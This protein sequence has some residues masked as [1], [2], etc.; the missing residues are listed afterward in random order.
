MK[1]RI[2]KE[3][4]KSWFNPEWDNYNEVFESE[5]Y[6]SESWGPEYIGI[7]EIKLW[8]DKWHKNLYL[9]EWNIIKINHI[10]NISF[11][12]WYF[13][14]SDN[15]KV[16][17]FNGVSIIEWGINDKILSL[18]EFASSL[19]KYNPTKVQK[20]NI[21]SDYPYGCE[22]IEITKLQKDP[23]LKIIY[24]FN[25]KNI[26]N[27]DLVDEMFNDISKECN[28]SKVWALF[29]SNIP[30][31][32]ICLQVASSSTIAREIISDIKCMIPFDENKDI[33]SWKGTFYDKEIFKVKYGLDARCQ[34][35]NNMYEQFNDFCIV[36]INA[37]KYLKNIDTGNFDPINYAE[38]KFAN[39]TKLL[40]WR[41]N[42]FKKESEILKEI[43]RKQKVY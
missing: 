37:E 4:F 39:D 9:I 33:K 5:I 26:L 18:K 31:K 40:Y 20:I 12:E 8:K 41:L 14:C 25:K 38:V 27:K 10:N 17:E 7:D 19:P 2:I 29:G 43:Q 35:Y 24:R 15:E 16:N 36:L 30:D 32:Y 34:K 21:C 28:D 13:S 3:W 42:S 6:Y 1:D 22:E 11:V 23:N